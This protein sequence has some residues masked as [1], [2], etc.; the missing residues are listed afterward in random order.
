M[1][2]VIPANQGSCTQ[3]LKLYFTKLAIKTGR[4]IVPGETSSTNKFLLDLSLQRYI[5]L[6]KRDS[7]S[8]T[9]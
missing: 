7:F 8:K 3:S 5:L 2:P 4:I 9:L 6:V 1:S